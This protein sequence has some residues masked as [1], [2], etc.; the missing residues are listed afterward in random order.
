[1]EAYKD[2]PI[3]YY[4]LDRPILMPFVPDNLEKVLDVG[5]GEGGF[6]RNLKEKKGVKEVWGVEF[7]EDAALKAKNNLDKVI[8]ARIEDALDLLPDNY[9]DCI[10]FNDVLEHLVDPYTVLEK[11]KRKCK[12]DGSVV[13][14][15]P[16]ILNFETLYLFLKNQDWEYKEF[17]I[18]DK[19]H[20]RFFTKKSIHRMFTQ[21]GYTIEIITGINKFYGKKFAILNFLLFNKL[22]QMKYIQ[23]VVRAKPN[24]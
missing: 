20:L 6:G 18:M 14:S 5:C 23:I 2:K 1:M 22:D 13:A 9:F 3:D 24:L 11:I 19:T 8:H 10:F 7:F 17:G 12:P 21:A 15:I 16:N 4:S